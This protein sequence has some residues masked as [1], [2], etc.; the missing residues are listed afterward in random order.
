[1]VLSS[2]QA[3]LEILR[4]GHK[5]LRQRVGSCTHSSGVLEALH[6]AHALLHARADNGALGVE[7]GGHQDTMAYAA[8]GFGF[9]F[10]F[11]LVRV[12]GDRTT[13]QRVTAEAGRLRF[14]VVHSL[15]LSTVD[16]RLQQ[17]VLYAGRESKALTW[18]G[19]DRLFQTRWD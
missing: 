4:A 7:G 18:E 14:C 10:G 8:V 3:A 9:G 12:A 15:T 13:P 1:M 19:M 2:L 16:A 17:Y 5:G 11:G 6:R